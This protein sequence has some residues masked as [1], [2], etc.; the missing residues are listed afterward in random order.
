MKSIKLMTVALA[1]VISTTVSTAPASA[2]PVAAKKA[3]FFVVTKLRS[4]RHVVQAVSAKRA[5]QLRSRG[6]V[7]GEDQL[8]GIMDAPDTELGDTSPI[9]PPLE[10]TP[11]STVPAPQVD[12][13]VIERRNN[14]VAVLDS[15]VDTANPAFSGAL[16]PGANFAVGPN[17]DVEPWLDG[18]GHGT[19]VAGIVREHNPAALIMPVRVLNNS[20]SGMTKD[21]VSGIYW[22]VDNGAAVINMSL[23]STKR[24]LETG[25]PLQT[26]I[27][28][29]VNRGVV[30]VAAAGNTGAEGSPLS[31]P[32]AFE[33]TISVSSYNSVNGEIS[34]FSS[35]RQDVDI[36][37][38]GQDIKVLGL[39][40]STG[41]ES[42]TSF[43][44]PVVAAAAASLLVAHPEWGA[45]QVRSQLLQ[46]ATDA[47]PKGPDAVFGF[48]KLN[49]QAALTKPFAHPIGSVPAPRPFTKLKVEQVVGGVS[50]SAKGL[51]RPLFVLGPSGEVVTVSSKGG[52][53]RVEEDGEF[54]VW[55]YDEYGA[56][57]YEAVAQSF[58]GSAPP[59]L[60]ARA[61]RKKGAIY[62]TV[63]TKLPKGL[64]VAASA[65]AT[66]EEST[67]ILESS[68][69]GNK[70]FKAFKARVPSVKACFEASGG[71]TFGCV[72][73]LVKKR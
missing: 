47:G 2:V 27:L 6:V 20:G 9:T 7:V 18:H 37:A 63:L 39:Q 51:K 17:S 60:K 61:F 48:G 54:I 46:T 22:A 32:A 57:A 38:P 4:G 30:V 72:D 19:A 62:V 36:S 1:M 26:A 3:S 5:A 21:V 16:L 52:Y 8:I 73:L 31:I 65:T 29:A 70:T 68:T 24:Q 42:G 33:E 43:S 71:V 67:L 12:T 45:T 59:K 56:P 35:R 53:V 50:L 25:S 44:A 13:P 66:A 49:L 15:G 23:G 41:V 11:P 10:E 58:I 40:G 34:R 28:H 14:V 64:K 55:A 69:T